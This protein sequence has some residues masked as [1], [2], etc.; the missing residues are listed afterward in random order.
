MESL[1]SANMDFA[2]FIKDW[3]HL[4]GCFSNHGNSPA[5]ACIF[6]QS[7]PQNNLMRHAKGNG[8]NFSCDD[9]QLAGIPRGNK[10][11]GREKSGAK[12]QDL[13]RIM[14]GA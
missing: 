10:S 2:K 8:D 5:T 4:L 6:D 7:H 3:L 1:E 12:G 13:D 11:S 9:E 14:F